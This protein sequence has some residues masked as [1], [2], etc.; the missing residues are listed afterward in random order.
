LRGVA[1]PARV[2]RPWLIALAVVAAAVVGG[3]RSSG[4]PNPPAAMDVAPPA[5]APASAPVVEPSAP[6]AVPS[7]PAAND[8]VLSPE[9]GVIGAPARETVAPIEEAPPASRKHKPAKSSRP[10]GAK[11][12]GVDRSD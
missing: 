5:A 12:L 8:V 1:N 4:A 7:A 11:P 2:L 10:G 3:L 6:A 9:I